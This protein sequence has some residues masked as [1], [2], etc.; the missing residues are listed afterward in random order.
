MS[1]T[2][3]NAA[4]YTEH[5]PDQTGGTAA[6]KVDKEREQEK[7]RRV[8]Q[9]K[10]NRS[11]GKMLEQ[12]IDAACQYYAR[13]GKAIIHK[14]PEPV[15]VLG[16]VDRAGRFQACFE[17]KAQPDY[18]G[19]LRNGKAIVFEAK[20]SES[21]RIAKSRLTDQQ[22]EILQQFHEMGAVSFVL[23]SLNL[24]AFYCVPWPVWADMHRN[25]GHKH[26]TPE[27]LEPFRG[28]YNEVIRFLG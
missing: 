4:Y 11:A 15:R 23:V 26:M 21:G 9:G 12:L 27:E 1:Q 16:K 14:T 2:I 5:Y 6:V 19:C 13:H 18:K 24:Q 10:A 3:Y 8:L 25:F 22:E 20:N 7:T 17:K 28:Q